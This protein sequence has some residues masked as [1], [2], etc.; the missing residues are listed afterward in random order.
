MG[1]MSGTADKI[2]WAVFVCA[3]L[4]AVVLAATR[5]R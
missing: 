3:L 1:L 2:L 4:L 5:I